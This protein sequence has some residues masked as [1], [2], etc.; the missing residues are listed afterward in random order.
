MLEGTK[1]M[2][3][4]VF[5]GG[6]TAGHITPNIALIENLTNYKI[7]YIGSQ[8]ME[9]QLIKNLKHVTY[10]S[11]PSVKFKRS[12]SPSN[13]LIPFKLIQSVK[14]ARKILEEI[15]PCIV[16]SK[17]GYVSLPTSIAAHQLHIPLL[18]HE[19]DYSLGLANKIIGKYAKYICCSFETTAKTIKKGKHTGSP[20]RNQIFKGNKNKVK[21]NF[22]NKNPI[23][24]FTG[25]SQGAKVLNEFIWNNLD[26]LVK[27]YN[28]IHIT[29]KNNLNTTIKHPNYLQVEFAT[30][31][32]DY[33]AL[34]DIVISRAGSNT[35]FELLAISKPMIL[36]PLPKTKHSRGDQ[37]LN[38][39]EFKLK[40]YAK[41]I[42]QS[43]LT[44]DILIENIN[45]IL[46]NYNQIITNM[47]SANKTSANEK[48][49]KLIQSIEL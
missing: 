19:S 11:I 8:P 1:T 31:I 7:Y 5:T 33:F 28:I 32:E 14:K 26:K 17:G 48:I 22:S 29:G 44:L 21:H 23:I 20:I 18:T 45:D 13:F 40:G 15:R 6:G 4:I 36:V 37:E 46:C 25:G 24:L 3:N 41:S 35:I 12:L 10:I 43:D 27:S 9:E 39:Q 49:I 34:A 47:K 30:N 2:K 42:K 16:F 38:A